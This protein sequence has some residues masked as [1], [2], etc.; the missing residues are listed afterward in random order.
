[1]I[2]CSHSS[3]AGYFSWQNVTST[4]A[5]WMFNLV[6]IVAC[7]AKMLVYGD[8]ILKYQSNESNKYWKHKKQSD[9]EFERVSKRSIYPKIHV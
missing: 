3:D 7:L 1:M 6:F 8:P 2:L 9:L 5:L 4:F